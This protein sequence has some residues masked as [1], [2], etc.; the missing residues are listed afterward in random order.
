MCTN[1]CPLDKSYNEY[2]DADSLF[3]GEIGACVDVYQALDKVAESSDLLRRNS[4]RIYG[5][6]SN[7]LNINCNG[8]AVYKTPLSE[9]SVNLQDY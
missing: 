9:R 5:S 6:F 4:W 7:E 3:G 2:G 8:N 1:V